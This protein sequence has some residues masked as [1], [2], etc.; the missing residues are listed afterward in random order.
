[1]KQRLPYLY[2][3]VNKHIASFK[4]DYLLLAS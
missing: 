2:N 1:M 4:K 3:L